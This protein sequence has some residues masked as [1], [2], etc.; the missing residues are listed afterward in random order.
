MSSPDLIM[1]TPQR[2]MLRLMDQIAVIGMKPAQRRRTLRIIGKQT[3]DNV[4]V[5]VRKQRTI[6]GRA[7]APRA[8]RRKRKM[9]RRLP[10]RM[11]TNVRNDHQADVTWKHG[12]QAMTAYRHH[13]G[14][15]ENYTAKKAARIYGK[16][17]YSKPATPAQAKALNR[18]GF[19][20]RV[21][22][23]RGKGGAVLKRVPQKWIRENMSMGQ[24]GLI[25]RL[26]R[27]GNRKGKQNWKIPVPE[28]P[29][30]GATPKEAETYLTAMA[31]DALRRIRQ[32]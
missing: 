25:L 14:I 4:R 15:P 31:E 26:M 29:I 13:H 2:D 17:D 12:G 20:R 16:P 22:R 30:L 27:T 28:R 5:N 24:A 9:F 8:N 1:R 18:E 21:K 7:M 3:R 23:Q 11:V 10:K 32:A 19:R 6:R